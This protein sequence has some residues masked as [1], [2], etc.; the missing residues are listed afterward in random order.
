MNTLNWEYEPPQYFI[1]RGVL[2]YIKVSSLLPAHLQTTWAG[3]IKRVPED[4]EVLEP[5]PRY[6]A[7]TKEMPLYLGGQGGYLTTGPDSDMPGLRVDFESTLMTRLGPVPAVA[8]TLVK[9]R[10]NTWAAVGWLA[11]HLSKALGRTIQE[12]Q[13]FTSGL[14]DR[15]AITAQT[16]VITGVTMA[17]MRTVTWWPANPGRAGFFLKDIRPA[18]EKVYQGDH[19]ANA[20]NIKV[21]LDGKTAAEIEQYVNPRVEFL[22]NNGW[23]IPNAFGRQRL[24]RRQNLHLIGRT[25]LTGDFE[26]PAGCNPF[27]SNVEAA[28]FRFLFETSD[29]EQSTATETRLA[30]QPMWQYNFEEMESLLRRVYRKVNLSFEYDVVSRLADTNRYGGSCEM[31]MDELRD[32]VSLWVGAWQAFYWNWHLARELSLSRIQASAGPAIPLL[33]ASGMSDAKRWYGRTACGQQALRELAATERLA[34]RYRELSGRGEA[35]DPA[36]QAANMVYRLFLVARE[37]K[38]GVEKDRAPWRKAFIRV[39]GFR[40]SCEDEVLNLSFA[41]RSGSYATMVAG[42]I[43]D[44]SDPDEVEG[45]EASVESE[46]S[47]LE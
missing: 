36:M 10:L 19:L 22:A 7:G 20:F 2:D 18:S 28:F 45:D 5:V 35:T 4:F 32:K 34:L 26:A 24:G 6:P 15:W 21:R 13:I 9:C 33:M 43:C 11:K 38:S 44:T 47:E 39:N 40:Y 1:P 17:E 29:N 30:M 8:A 12:H 41:L 23:W 46:V 25:L 16:V 3:S 42:L 31:V 27:M 14:K 37:R